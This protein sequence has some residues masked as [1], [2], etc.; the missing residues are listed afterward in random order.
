MPEL[1]QPATSVALPVRP[2]K[3]WYIRLTW[4]V[5][6]SVPVTKASATA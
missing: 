4:S 3:S 1:T 6:Y 5:R 2:R